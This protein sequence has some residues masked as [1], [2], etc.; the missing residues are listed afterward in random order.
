MVRKMIL[1]AILVANLMPEHVQ[2]GENEKG[3]DVATPT[4]Y[5]AVAVAGRSGMNILYFCRLHTGQSTSPC[6]GQS[7]YQWSAVN[8]ALPEPC[9]CGNLLLLSDLQLTPQNRPHSRLR[10][11]DNFNG[12]LPEQFP[13][14]NEDGEVRN[15]VNP[16][17]ALEPSVQERVYLVHD[18]RIRYF[19]MTKFTLNLAAGGY[20]RGF[21]DSAS[22]ES[23][24]LG[25]ECDA[26]ANG[27]KDLTQV[28]FN[29]ASRI[30][31][32][33]KSST[34]WS[35]QSTTIFFAND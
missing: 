17:A 34:T 18:G 32:Y 13:P 1:A 15:E 26:P 6:T 20:P 28:P 35:G 22:S 4:G 14:R 21:E 24:F 29:A 30:D 3:V 9:P 27:T 31:V 19:L 5:C 10:I 8:V 7:S 33:G 25:L 2:G 11:R 16:N 12:R 23:Q